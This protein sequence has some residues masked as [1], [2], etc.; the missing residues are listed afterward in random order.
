MRRR[1]K[2]LARRLQVVGYREQDRY[3]PINNIQRCACQ[4]YRCA[5][6]SGR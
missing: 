2:T 1:L 6:S 4:P 5:G 3:L